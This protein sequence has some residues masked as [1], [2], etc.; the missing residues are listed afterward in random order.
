[1]I[2]GR[3]EDMA[4]IVRLAITIPADM[5]AM[6]KVVVDGVGYTLSSE[7]ACEALHKWK[8]RRVVQE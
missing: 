2:H 3:E 5:A 1:M 7:V 6:M 8:L 4:S